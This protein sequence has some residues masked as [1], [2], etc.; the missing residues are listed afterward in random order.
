M[1]QCQGQ[2]WKPGL[3]VVIPGKKVTLPDRSKDGRTQS[4]SLSPA[5]GRAPSARRRTRAS[6]RGDVPWASLTSPPGRHLR[7]WRWAR[8]CRGQGRPV[9]KRKTPCRLRA[10]QAPGSAGRVPAGPSAS[11]PLCRSSPPPPPSA[12]RS[13]PGFMPGPCPAACPASVGTSCLFEEEIFICIP[14]GQGQC[15][16]RERPPEGARVR[17]LEKPLPRLAR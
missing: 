10:H 17:A 13:P 1:S 16:S 6:K 3:P 11:S 8:W 14:R 15:S 9:V 2:L 5:G 4:Q 7:A 12:L